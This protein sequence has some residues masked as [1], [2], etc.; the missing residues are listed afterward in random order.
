MAE[1]GEVVPN[2][3]EEKEIEEVAKAKLSTQ[4]PRCLYANFESEDFEEAYLG[5]LS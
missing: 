2:P 4:K 1:V 3:E 5:P